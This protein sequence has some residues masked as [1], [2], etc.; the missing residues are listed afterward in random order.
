MFSSCSKTTEEKAGET[1]AA[2][3]NA[4]FN[5]QFRRSLDFCTPDSRR[6]LSFMASQVGQ[7]DVDFLRARKES[8]RAEVVSVKLMRGDT[9]A[10]AEVEAYEFLAM[11]SLYGRRK[12]EKEARFII[13]AKLV[14]NQWKVCLTSPLRAER[15]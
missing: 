1:V 3:A 9:L 2:F 6:W 7:E 8:A 14:N 12:I 11:D 15:D 13:F 4:Y 5:W 10:K